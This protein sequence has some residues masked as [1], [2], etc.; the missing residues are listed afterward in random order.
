MENWDIIVKYLNQESS[1]SEK[2]ELE[3]WLKKDEANA[4]LFEELKQTWKNTDLAFDDANFDD[5][6]A[7]DRVKEKIKKEDNVIPIS[8]RSS[9]SMWFLRIAAILIVGVFSLWYYLSGEGPAEQL[10]AQTQNS[11]KEVKLPDG[12]TVWLNAYSKLSYPKEFN[13]DIRQ[14]QLEGEAFFDVSHNKQHPFLISNKDF[15]V[16]VL[17]T[18]FNIKGYS[19]TNEVLVTVVTGTVAFRSTINNQ[20]VILTKDESGVLNKK[21]GLLTEAGNENS[22]FMAWKTHQLKFDNTSVNLVCN[23]LENYFGIDI[24]VEDKTIYNCKF[25]GSF[26]NAKLQDVLKIMEASLNIKVKTNQN[27]ITISGK[28]C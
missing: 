19:N 17:G 1:P 24:L 27:R 8:G 23:T 26:E 9:G 21:N 10:I 11:T 2:E 12:S 5:E 13:G 18:S 14:V 3:A 20:E 6:K 15:D 16:K 7:L 25:T 4:L 28:G 22:N